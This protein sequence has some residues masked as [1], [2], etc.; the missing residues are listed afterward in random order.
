[1]C[2]VD[3]VA[4]SVVRLAQQPEL[5]GRRWHMTGKGCGLQQTLDWMADACGHELQRLPLQA[6]KQRLEEL[7]PESALW[8]LLGYFRSGFPCSPDW[9]D[10]DTRRQCAALNT[11]QPVLTKRL[12][13]Q[14]VAALGPV[15]ADSRGKQEAE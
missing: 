4:R 9:R 12:V 6:W 7:G 13:G 8:P 15:G 14:Y 3:W 1:M 2:P 11:A 10:A 5:V